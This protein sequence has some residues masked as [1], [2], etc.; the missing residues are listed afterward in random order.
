MKTMQE[1]YESMCA[2]VRERSG[3]SITE[4]GELSLRLRAIAQEIYGL[5]AESD[6]VRRQCFPQTALS[7]DL[8]H[9]AALR[10]LQRRASARAQGV[11]RFA[12]EEAREEPL[13]IAQGTVCATAQQRRFVTREA[14]TIQ[15]GERF[16]EVEAYAEEEGSGGNV[17]AGEIGIMHAPPVGVTSCTNPYPFTGGSDEEDDE[18]LRARVLEDYAML[19]NGANKGY[20]RALALSVE[21]VAAAATIACARGGNTVDVVIASEEGVASQAL[22]Q[23]VSA[24]FSERRELGTDVCVRSAR[25]RTFSVSIDA[26]LK[27]GADLEAVRAELEFNLRRAITGKLLGTVVSHQ[28]MVAWIG[29]V[30]GLHSY[31]IGNQEQILL[32]EDEIPQLERVEVRQFGTVQA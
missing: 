13:S 5:Y 17:A 23:R 24:L 9:H 11:L 28:A 22:M 1:I 15:A 19:S 4:N 32:A 27:E 8:E 3:V 16:A 29:A 2:R 10:G 26:V 31:N 6:W 21:G 20:Y 18:S 12:V 14:C 25:V 30:E 7:E